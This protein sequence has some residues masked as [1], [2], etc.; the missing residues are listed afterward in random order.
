MREIKNFAKW[1]ANLDDVCI[2]LKSHN[3]VLSEIP[4]D[5]LGRSGVKLARWLRDMRKAYFDE[6]TLELS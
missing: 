5:A 2:Y 3:C 1:M 4:E 6:G